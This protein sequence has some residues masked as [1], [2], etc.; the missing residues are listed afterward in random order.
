[1]ILNKS[2]EVE[3]METEKKIK[4]DNQRFFELIYQSDE[5]ER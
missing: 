2:D 5:A 4:K 3:K 1:M